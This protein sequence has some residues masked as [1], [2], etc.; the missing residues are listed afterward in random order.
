MSLAPVLEALKEIAAVSSTTKKKELIAQYQFLPGFRNT[1]VYAYHPLLQFNILSISGSNVG[2]SSDPSHRDIFSYLKFLSSKR[3]ATDEERNVLDGLCVDKETVEVVNRILNKDLRCGAGPILFGSVFTIPN[4]EPMLCE[5][6]LEKMLKKVDGDMTRLAWSIKL[7]G[8]RTRAIL[9]SSTSPVKY[10]SRNGKAYNNFTL[11]DS[12]VMEYCINISDWYGGQWPII[13]DG[14]VISK[15]KDFQK[16]MT[17]VHRLEGADPSIFKFEVFDF[18]L[19]PP[20]D[21][22]PMWTRYHILSSTMGGKDGDGVELLEHIGFPSDTTIGD[23][24][25]LSNRLCDNGEEGIVV[26]DKNSL[27]QPGRSWEWTK[28]KKFHTEDLCVIG[29]EEGVGKHKGRLGALIVERQFVHGGTGKRTSIPV[30]VGS[31]YSDE[32]RED[33]WAHPPQMIEVKYQSETNEG[34]L[35]FPVFVRVRDDKRST[36]V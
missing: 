36:E 5:D 13:L 2:A 8:V 33:L 20:Y 34:S 9:E 14:E 22:V 16:Q 18:I 6:N 29:K 7:D 28:V 26:K 21:I 15:D 1:V 11:F 35:R 10:I 27:Y 25:Y 3:G 23:I 4:P 31:G 30:K 24:L 32:E 19:P 12:K 17:Q